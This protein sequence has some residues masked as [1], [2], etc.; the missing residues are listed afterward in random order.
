MVMFII[1]NQ[2]R[3]SSLENWVRQKN[4]H[5]NDEEI[6]SERM[7]EKIQ[8]ENCFICEENLQPGDVLKHLCNHF[9][10][11]LDKKYSVDQTTDEG[12]FSCS[13]CGNTFEDKFD[14]LDHMGILHKGVEE[15]IPVQYRYTNMII[16]TLLRIP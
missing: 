11:E 14:F 1:S 13:K 16:N 9:I 3:T 5:T 7:A 10:L 6:F 4:G 12:L 15:F 2:N 8:L